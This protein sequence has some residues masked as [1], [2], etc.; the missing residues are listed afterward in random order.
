MGNDKPRIVR[1]GLVPNICVDDVARDQE[2]LYDMIT[3]EISGAAN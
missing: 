3:V 2:L 1:A